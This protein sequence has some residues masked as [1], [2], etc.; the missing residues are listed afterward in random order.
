MRSMSFRC[1]FLAT[2]FL[3]GPLSLARGA[4]TPTGDV[5]PDPSTW[6][7]STTGYI[8]EAA[9]GTLTVDSGSSLLSDYGFI[10][11]GSTAMGQVSVDGPGSNWT[12]GDSLSVG[13][14][15]NGILSIT[16]G[17]S[18]SNS[19]GNIGYSGSAGTVTVD[20]AGS[21]WTNGGSL[22]VGGNTS[23]FFSGSGTGTLS[24][25]NGGA[26]SSVGGY[27]GYGLG[28]TGAVTVDGPGSVYNVYNSADLSIGYSGNG[29]LAI[30]NRGAVN[31][32]NTYIGFNS[33]STGLVTVDGPGS[34]WTNNSSLFVGNSGSGTL[35]I[36]NG[37]GVNSYNGSYIGQNAGSSGVV[38]VNG[39]G[40]NWNNY[41][42]IT[43]GYS[44]S[45]TLSI[46]NGGAVTNSWGNACIGFAPGS[47]GAV[48]VD[49][50]GSNW[51]N[52]GGSGLYVGY[53]GDGALSISNG[54]A[55]SS[56]NGY[57]GYIGYYSGSSGTVTVDGAGSRWT[58][59]GALFV[60]GSDYSYYPL[61]GVGTLAITNGGAVSSANGYIGFAYNSSGAVTVDGPGS[62]WANGG[63]VFVGGGYYSS[64]GNGILSITNGGGVSNYNGYIGNNLGSTGAVTVDGPG[65]NWT[66]YYGVTVG[67]YGAG[68]LSIT[69]RGTVNSYGGG[70]IG[71]Y[72]GSSGTVAVDGPGST[73]TNYYGVT[74]GYSGSGSLSITN[75]GAVSNLW[76]NSY[77]GYTTGSWGAVTVDG[78]GSNWNNSGGSALYVG[79]SGNGM[80]S[81]TNGGAVSNSGGYIGAYNGSSGMVTVDGTGSRWTSGGPLYVGGGDYSYYYGSGNG[82]LAITNGGAVSNTDAHIGYGLGSTGAVTVDGPGSIWANSGSL[83]VGGDNNYGGAGT[84]SVTNGAAVSVTAQTYVGWLDGSSGAIQFGGNGGTLTTQG[85]FVSPRNSAALARSSPAD[86]SATSISS[87][88]L[89]IPSANRSPSPTRPAKRSR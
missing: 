20:G 66:N 45:G 51:N 87:S 68:T 76:G 80:L 54:G 84:L 72:S 77:I 32:Y 43:V 62:T 18:V 83:Y 7:G 26:V 88:I 33:G 61:G 15:G 36:T 16:N 71:N 55:V 82:T 67:Y 47:W 64:V 41:Y 49:G 10:G 3:F 14:L 63:D 11:Y 60:G 31:C 70:S 73:W 38:S 24:I 78:P 23:V 74:V 22:Y 29:S 52:N 42:G 1:A 27:V 5:N 65:S 21:S 40:S 28:S 44:G 37:G 85:I 89:L 9:A 53:G 6:D 2:L 4:I 59:G 13:F 46:S 35:S 56:A 57:I 58:D 50:P 39:P 75:G 12:N 34:T 48:T 69:N 86:W 8:G 25:T 30:T 81:I 19:Y 17:G 79:Y